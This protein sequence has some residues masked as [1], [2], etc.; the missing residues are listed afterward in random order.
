MTLSRVRTLYK[1]PNGDTWRTGI[2]EQGKL[3]VLHE[4]NLASGGKPTEMD[5]NKFLDSDHYGPEHEAL[6]SVI[7]GKQTKDLS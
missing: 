5:V 3:I 6:L 1:S 7:T 4:P 2:N